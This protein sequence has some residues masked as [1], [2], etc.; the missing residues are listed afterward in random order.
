MSLAVSQPEESA[1]SAA[2]AP[3]SLEAEVLRRLDDLGRRLDET[4]QELK[5]DIQSKL[6]SARRFSWVLLFIAVQVVQGVI[7]VRYT[8]RAASTALDSAH[9]P[10]MT[11]RYSE[12]LR[13]S[14]ELVRGL[15][16]NVST[17]SELVSATTSSWKE[18]V[19][20]FVHELPRIQEAYQRSA[21]SFSQE[22]GTLPARIVDRFFEAEGV[23]KSMQNY[24]T[25]ID[26][27]AGTVQKRS[28][29]GIAS[30]LKSYEGRVS[31]QDALVHFEKQVEKQFEA[32]K[33]RIADVVAGS[34]KEAVQ[35]AQLKEKLD[36]FFA[37]GLLPQG[38][39]ARQLILKTEAAE[40]DKSLQAAVDEALAPPLKEFFVGQLAPSGPLAAHLT[41]DLDKL[42]AMP[43]LV[44]ELVKRR[45]DGVITLPAG[46]KLIALQDT[47]T[48][49][50]KARVNV[51][52]AALHPAK[53]PVLLTCSPQ[54][55]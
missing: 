12:S 2:P 49:V 33:A 38:W 23:K 3:A 25:G 32:D 26:A 1:L 35:S 47:L 16:Q 36:G 42:P 37:A 18:H 17:L 27:A 43:Q 9:I 30:A 50:V 15:N 48:D 14:Q 20:E 11:S 54:S 46:E 40:V 24:T 21:R 10:E 19:Q 6:P 34:A 53:G 45:I 55:P 5:S 31:G 39:L 22:A 51:T 52:L 44:T 7:V 28:D 13:S 29:D 4:K 8:V 41:R